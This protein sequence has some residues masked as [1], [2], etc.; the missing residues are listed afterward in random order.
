MK[1]AKHLCRFSLL[2]SL[3]L[4]S[5]SA[6]VALA[7][8][9]EKP[10]TVAQTDEIFDTLDEEPN[11]GANR[12]DLM[13]YLSQNIRYP[14]NSQKKGEQGRVIVQFI[15]ERDGSVRDAKVVRSVSKDLD[16]E[17]L[18]VVR[19]MPK[20]TPGKKDGKAVRARFTL[21]VTFRLK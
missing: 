17:A 7:Q 4:G 1:T 11:F 2:L 18:R 10:Q 5:S 13:Q 9:P 15:V 21:P 12:S 8:E 20:W 6:Y 16:K 3:V 14:K 19:Q